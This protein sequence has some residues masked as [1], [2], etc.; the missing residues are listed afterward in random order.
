MKKLN[1]LDVTFDQNNVNF[2]DVT[3]DQNNDPWKA[4][5]K[6]NNTP[7]YINIKSNHLRSQS[8]SIKSVVH[9]LA[10]NSNHA[11]I[12]NNDKMDNKTALKNIQ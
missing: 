6:T 7:V 12:F 5:R 1:F 2:I 9:R 10:T 11:N 4:Y 3:F 8:R